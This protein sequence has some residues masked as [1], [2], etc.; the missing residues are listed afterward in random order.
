MEDSY[1]V[2]ED[3]WGQLAG[4]GKKTV[5][6]DHIYIYIYFYIYIYI[7]YILYIM[8]IYILYYIYYIYTLCF[9]FQ[10]F[11]LHTDIHIC[12]SCHQYEIKAPTMGLSRIHGTMWLWVA[13][14]GHHEKKA[15]G[16]GLWNS[17]WWLFWLKIRFTQDVSELIDTVL[18]EAQYCH[19]LHFLGQPTG[20]LYV[21]RG[22]I[23]S[24]L[25]CHRNSI[26]RNR[27]GRSCPSHLAMLGC[28]WIFL[29]L[30]RVTRSP[31]RPSK[32]GGAEP[33]KPSWPHHW[34]LI[35]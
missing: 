21:L 33:A 16:T 8:Y 12:T 10:T 14:H 4:F 23:G 9:V 28:S 20:H 1:L 25:F 17:M 31:A 18:S 19:F 34:W 5:L 2:P 29:K 32:N 7:I 35:W 22:Y 27:D 11:Q 13:T 30:R 24:V 15:I 6:A 3:A 26:P